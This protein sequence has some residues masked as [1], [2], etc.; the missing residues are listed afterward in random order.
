M[1]SYPMLLNI[2]FLN[3]RLS[4]R[5]LLARVP[6]VCAVVSAMCAVTNVVINGIASLV[7]VVTDLRTWKPRQRQEVRIQDATHH[8]V[9]AGP[10]TWNV[11]VRPIPADGVTVTRRPV[12]VRV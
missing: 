5:E 12:G 3:R 6:I 9:D 11:H 8:R 4:R 7:S 10:V 2:N 1:I